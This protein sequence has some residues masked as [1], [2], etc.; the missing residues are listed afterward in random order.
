MSGVPVGELAILA[1]A[2]AA[3]ASSPASWR[4][5]SASAAVIVPVLYDDRY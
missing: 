4:A 1:V 3:V 2:I 5:R